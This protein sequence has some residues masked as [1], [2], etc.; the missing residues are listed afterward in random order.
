MLRYACKYR[1]MLSK[2]MDMHSTAFTTHIRMSKR[3][4]IRATRT[5]IVDREIHW[6]HI[7]G[8]LNKSSVSYHVAMKMYHLCIIDTPLS[9]NLV[10]IA[11]IYADD[12]SRMITCL[13]KT[14]SL[15]GYGKNA[16][17]MKNMSNFIVSTYNNRQARFS[18]VT[19][20]FFLQSAGPLN[21][22]FFINAT[23]DVK[24]IL[25]N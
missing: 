11:Q 12:L 10:Y 2:A 17:G 14:E 22:I 20:Q 18:L 7:R 21:F 8:C 13:L 1:Y 25:G 9:Q 16:S 24:D 6:Y 23:T 15:S 4:L 19:P 5:K 3:I